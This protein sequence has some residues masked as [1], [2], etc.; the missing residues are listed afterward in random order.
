MLPKEFPKWRTCHY[1]FTIWSEKTN[2]SSESVLEKVLKKIVREIRQ[3]NDRDEKSSF[4]IIDAQS[5]K[6]M[7]CRAFPLLG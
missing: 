1:Y 4:I 2:D 7:G 3:N 6:N 5:V